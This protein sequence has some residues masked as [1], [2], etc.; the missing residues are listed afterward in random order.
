MLM[1]LKLA[2]VGKG[3]HQTRMAV[4][5][6]WDP[7]KLSRIVNEV[8]IPTAAERALIAEHLEISEGE[9]FPQSER[10]SDLASS[11]R[12]P[13]SAMKNRGIRPKESV[14]RKSPTERKTAV[15]C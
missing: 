13:D 7:A 11:S 8:T 14:R 10:E 4:D 3:I 15:H 12:P 6:G 1:A 5:L 9:L 2:M